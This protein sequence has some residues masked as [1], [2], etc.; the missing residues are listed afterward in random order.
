LYALKDHRTVWNQ[1]TSL[2]TGL[3]CLI[4]QTGLAQGLALVIDEAE[5]CA[6]P[7][8]LDQ[9]HGDRTLTGLCAAALGPRAVRRPE[10][11]RQPG[12]HR[13][14]RE[15]PPFH[16]GR[17]HLYLA[18]GMASQASGREALQRLLPRD[19]FVE[20]SPFSDGE[21]ARLAERIVEIYGQAFPHFELG[22]G[23]AAPLVRLLQLRGLCTARQIVQQTMAF[24]DGARL[25]PD[26]VESYLEE[27]LR[28]I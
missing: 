4:R 22:K 9:R 8:S 18:L 11:L 21:A 2:L 16:R 13:S 6:L 25:W 24:L 27:C 1:L 19:T 10:L 17:S 12:G 28:G 3:S 15:F 5:M 26:S 14:S 23:L 7:S 20:L